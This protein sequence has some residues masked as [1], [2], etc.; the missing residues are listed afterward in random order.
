MRLLFYTPATKSSTSH[1]RIKNIRSAL[2]AN[3]KSTEFSSPSMGPFNDPAMASKA[4]FGLDPFTSNPGPDATVPTGTATPGIVVPFVSVQFV[5]TEPRPTSRARNGRN[6]IEQ[7]VENF[8]VVNVCRRQQKGQR[9]ALSIDEKMVFRAR[10]AFVRRVRP[11]FFAPF[12]AATVAESTAA[13]LQSISP[14]RPNFSS[15]RRCKRCQ[16]QPRAIP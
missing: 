2:I 12:F 7:I 5:R 8:G 14:A 13:R 9:N 10:F 15:N 4:V 16:T 1:G 3:P 11:G 6:A